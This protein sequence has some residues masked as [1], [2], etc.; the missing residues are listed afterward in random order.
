MM[1]SNEP[2]LKPETAISNGVEEA[3]ESAEHCNLQLAIDL[4]AN[5]TRLINVLSQFP[6]IALWLLHKYE[7]SV[8]ESEQASEAL[9]VAL[10]KIKSRYLQASL[11]FSGRG[12]K[13]KAETDEKRHLTEALQAFPFS[14]DDLL[15]L[16]E[17]II[18]V[19]TNREGGY[20]SAAQNVK[21]HSA[22]IVKRLKG[23]NRH[24]KLNLPDIMDAIRASQFD[25]QFLFLSGADMQQYVT[26][27]IVAERLWLN[28][29][30][31]LAE[32]NSGLVLFIAN[33][34]KCGFLDFDD[35]VQEGQ[36]GLLKAIDKFDHRLGFQFSTYA[37]Y[38]IRQAISRA[39]SRSERVVRVPCEQVANIHKVLRAKNELL[40]K[41]GKE[42]SIKELADYSK[43]PDDQINAILCISQTAVSLESLE[44]DEDSLAP[45]D[46]LEQQVFAHPFKKI[47]QSDLKD[48]IGNAIKVLDPRELKVICCHFGVNTDNEMTLQEIGAELNLTRE[49]VRQIQVKALNKMKLSYGNQLMSFL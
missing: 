2:L 5:K 48:W 18:C 31:A 32:A 13:R 17:F 24:S 34:Y 1:C 37:A 8:C 3:K 4:E 43:I 46:F 20:Q 44:D 11:S 25:E 23:S 47:E 49:R 10:A 27:M 36:T 45:I 41:T 9:T 26:D 38:W 12:F 21:N 7:A 35:L 6:A 22:W 28:S 15:V 40:S 29:R 30:Q 14:V 42:P 19:F 39:L 33:R 16:I